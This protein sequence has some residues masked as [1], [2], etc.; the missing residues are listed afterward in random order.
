MHL[1]LRGLGVGPGDEV[2]VK[3]FF[4]VQHLYL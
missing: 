4:R 1:A 2:W 3:L